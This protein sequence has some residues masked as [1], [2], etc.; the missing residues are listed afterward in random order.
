ML[1]LSA[2]FFSPLVFLGFHFRDRAGAWFA[3]PANNKGVTVNSM[4]AQR[5][6]ESFGGSFSLGLRGRLMEWVGFC[7]A[8]N[9]G[10]N[11]TGE[12]VVIQLLLQLH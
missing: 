1:C 9:V 5:I 12:P 8:G 6:D 4:L 11:G 7:R 10:S 2:A 3:A